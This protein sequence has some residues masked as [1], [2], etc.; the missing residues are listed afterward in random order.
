MTKRRKIIQI[1]GC[2]DMVY[3][4]NSCCV[5][6]SSTLFALCDDG[7]VWRISGDDYIPM[8]NKEWH[9][10]PDVPQGPIQPPH[11]VKIK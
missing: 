1:S 10:L 2:S 5:E 7:S 11:P 6:Y 3:D 4:E 9:K 8:I